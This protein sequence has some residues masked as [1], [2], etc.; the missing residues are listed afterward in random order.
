MYAHLS[1]GAWFLVLRC[2]D[3]MCFSWHGVRPA[4]WQRQLMRHRGSAPHGGEFQSGGTEKERAE[5]RAKQALYPDRYMYLGA[6]S[7]YSP[8]YGERWH[9]YVKVLV[10]DNKGTP[11][12]NKYGGPDAYGMPF[13]RFIET[14]WAKTQACAIKSTIK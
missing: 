1:Y 14:E 10:T 8:W 5:L 11:P 12:P 3:A 7:S 6:G 9:H 13:E 2:I 4:A